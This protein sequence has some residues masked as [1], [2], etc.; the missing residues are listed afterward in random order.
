MKTIKRA[1][2]SCTDRSREVLEIG[3]TILRE[4]RLQQA[5]HG[6][7]NQQG[8]RNHDHTEEQDGLQ[9][10][11]EAGTST[12]RHRL[13]GILKRAGNAHCFRKTLI[14]PKKPALR[15]RV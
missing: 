3:P 1:F 7:N 13:V 4:S 10:Q 6:E 12:V 8:K 14:S 5:F 2:K 15:N 9:A 11:A